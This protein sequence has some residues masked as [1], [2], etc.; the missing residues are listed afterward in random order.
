M[1]T[2]AVG[3]V[4]VMVPALGIARTD[5]VVDTTTAGGADFG[6][7]VGPSYGYVSD[8]E[9]MRRRAIAT[10]SSYWWRRYRACIN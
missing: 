6:I 2:V 1:S 4:M 7:Y 9:W 3:I 10:G 5:I 8:C